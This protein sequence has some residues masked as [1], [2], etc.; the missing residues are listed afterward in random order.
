MGDMFAPPARKGLRASDIRAAMSKRWRDPEWAIM[1]EVGE[2]TGAR[3]GRFA[4]AVMMSLWP[5]RGLELH[6]VEIKISRADWKR[7]AA[8]P[9][10]AEAVAKFCDRWWIH[11]SPGVVDDLSD[12]PPAWGLREFDGRAWR[13]IR[14]AEKTPADP[15]TRTFLAAMLRRADGV[16][17]GLMDE[18]L[19]DARDAVYAEA[20]QN[21]K[22][23]AA[24]VEDAVKR[25]TESLQ[26][27]MKNINLFEAAFGEGQ[28]YSW[29]CDPAAWGRA[30][31]A[32]ADCNA[33]YT[34]LVGRL[35]KA[36]DE[37]EALQ[38][39]AGSTTNHT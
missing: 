21:R 7:E 13:T 29:G 6:G 19:R 35:R 10:K 4:D 18:A 1:W 3:S 11:T 33:N 23:F 38:A 22:R 34:P 20:E 30:A 36:A 15:I 37:I 17:K 32:L 9:A 8:D 25:R 27:G 24:S 39:L 28:A 5:S 12:L 16:M 26:M 2:G 31:R 14:E